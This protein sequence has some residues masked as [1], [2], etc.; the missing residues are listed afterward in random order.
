MISTEANCS[1][2]VPLDQMHNLA[3][4]TDD[5]SADNLNKWAA[6]AGKDYA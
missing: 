6:P 1:E 2:S 3:E 5:N 4:M